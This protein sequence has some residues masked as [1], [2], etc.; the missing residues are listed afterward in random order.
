MLDEGVKLVELAAPERYSKKW[1]GEI[2]RVLPYALGEKDASG[3]PR[4]DQNRRLSH[5]N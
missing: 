1:Q 2:N 4:P 3:R 5:S